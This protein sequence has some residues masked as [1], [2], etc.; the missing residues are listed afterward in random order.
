MKISST[1]RDALAHV[2]DDWQK[3]TGGFYVAGR[4]V[5]HPLFHPTFE[6]LTRRKLVER[7]GG[8]GTWQWRKAPKAAAGESPS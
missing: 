4:F 5:D 8:P 3:M 2:P 6:A 7:R 1:M